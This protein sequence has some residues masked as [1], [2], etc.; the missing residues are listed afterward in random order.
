M[1]FSFDQEEKKWSRMHFQSN[2]SKSLKQEF[3]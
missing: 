1:T 2:W 3:F